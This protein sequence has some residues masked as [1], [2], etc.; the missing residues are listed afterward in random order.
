MKVLKATQAQYKA[1]E[2]YKNGSRILRFATDANGNYIIGKG[3]LTHPAYEA[4][5]SELEELEEIDYI[6]PAVEEE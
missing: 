5:R 3:V 2:G 1:L 6:A 4:K